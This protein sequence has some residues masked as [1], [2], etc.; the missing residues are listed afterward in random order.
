MNNETQWDMK[1]LEEL[2]STLDLYKF[3]LSDGG[4]LVTSG[5]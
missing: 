5:G 4:L 1:T 3:Q 2:R